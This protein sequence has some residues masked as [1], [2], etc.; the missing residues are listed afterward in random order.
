MNLTNNHWQNELTHLSSTTFPF[1]ATYTLSTSKFLSLPPN[2]IVPLVSGVVWV[3]SGVW[4]QVCQQF[5][6][7]SKDLY[8]HLFSF[9][10]SSDLA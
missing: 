9:Q 1:L 6:A 8:L 3:E 10:I 7:N 2:N 5:F 4:W